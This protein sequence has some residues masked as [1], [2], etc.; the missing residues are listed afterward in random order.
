MVDVSKRIKKVPPY[1]FAELDRKKREAI[2]RGVDIIT[3]GIGDPD[4]PTPQPIID[5]LKKNVDNPSNHRYPA[6]DGSLEFKKSVARW[7]KERFNLELDPET[8]VMALIGSKEGIA[9]LYFAYIDEGDYSLVPDPA[10]PVYNTATIFAGGEPYTMPLLKEN[11]FLP[12]FSKIPE[13]ILKKSKIMMLNYPNNPTGAICDLDLYEKAV[14]IGKKY[15]I[16]ICNDC[17]YQELAFD[18]YK[19]PSFLEAKGAMDVGIE[20]GSLSKPFNMTGW[21]I[22]YV[23]GNREAIK[24]LGVIKTNIDSGQFTAIQ[25]AAITGLDS[26][27]N[28]IS[29]MN[30]VYKERRDLLV[31]GLKELGIEVDPPKASFYL[32]APVPKGYTSTDFAALLLEKGGIIVGPGNA[33]GEYGEGFFRM[34]LTVEADR[35]KE[36][37]DRMKKIL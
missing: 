8:E 1:F 2:K 25:D 6:Y 27:S 11:G 9:H 35:I 24:N 36:A 3:F 13:N 12:D 26:C 29:D 4:R 22:G 19:A 33:Y 5:S 32:W 15:D 30:S 20:F 14:E 31:R 37:L 17:A 23:V 16:L 7:Y 28:Y 10:Y 21:R 18:G 34:A